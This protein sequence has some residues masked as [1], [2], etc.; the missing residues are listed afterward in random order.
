M[1]DGAL[2]IE[3][4]PDSQPKLSLFKLPEP[5]TG[6]LSSESFEGFLLIGTKDIADYGFTLAGL[7]RRDHAKRLVGRVEDSYIQILLRD[8]RSTGASEQNPRPVVSQDRRPKDGGLDSAHP[9][10]KALFAALIPILTNALEHC[11]LREGRRSALASPKP[12]VPRTEEAGRRSALASPKPCV[13][14]TKRQGAA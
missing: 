5:I 10:T 4:Y 6:E 8:Y 13:P 14:R 2:E 1:H 9:Y 3:G 7:E 12:C 11:S